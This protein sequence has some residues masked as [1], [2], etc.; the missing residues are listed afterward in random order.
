MKLVLASGNRG[1]L[2]E[3]S[4]VLQGRDLQL[5]PQSQLG[6]ENAEEAGF[7]FIENALIKARH[8][9]KRS[10]LPALADDSGLIIDALDGRPGLISAHYAGT[11]G[12]S[13]GNIA[14]VLG[15]LKGITDKHRTARFY[16]VIVVLRHADD[17]QPLIA[18][19]IWKGRILNEPRGIGGFGY[20]PIFF[21][22]IY[23][24]SA[25]ELI[26]DIKNQIS[27]RGRALAQLAAQLQTLV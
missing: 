5:I 21:D 22:P 2:D 24:K 27:H 4:A 15:E 23:D 19:G 1:K 11:H 26:P 13:S 7:T 9:A 12:D 16:S 18:E 25:A 10:G 17:P 20:D 3:I 6:I 14:K 8:A